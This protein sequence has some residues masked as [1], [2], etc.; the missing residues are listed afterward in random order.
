MLG[1]LSG[2]LLMMS[3]SS[4]RQAELPANKE[5]ADTIYVTRRGWHTGILVPAAALD[6]FFPSIQKQMPG[7]THVAFSWG[8]RRYFMAEE[9]TLGLAIR[10]ALLP[11]ESVVYVEGFNWLP[12][13]YTKSE[14]VI[15]VSL[16]EKGLRLMI[17]YIEQSFER[18]SRQQLIPLRQREEGMSHF[19]LSHITYWGTRTCNVWIARALAKAGV[20]IHPA[21]SLTAGR[22]MRQLKERK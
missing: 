12:K 21:L 8:D 2:L 10:A 1:W 14:N 17:G 20:D 7:A 13:G 19:Y 11:T 3:C 6:T 9:G 16:S 4:L 22:V 5:A 18:D 15:P